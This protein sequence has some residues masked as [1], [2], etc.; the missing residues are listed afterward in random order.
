MELIADSF[1]CILATQSVGRL[2]SLYLALPTL[3]G[4]VDASLGL[5]VGITLV[6][7]NVF[8][9]VFQPAFASLQLY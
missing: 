4:S 7:S 5:R 2:K 9:A 3:D 8:K 6:N 1:N